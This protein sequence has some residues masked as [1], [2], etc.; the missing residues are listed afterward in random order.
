MHDASVTTLSDPTSVSAPHRPTGAGDVAVA[1]LL[2]AAELVLAW[3]TYDLASA[4]SNHLNATRAVQWTFLML[5]YLPLALVVAVR[6]LSPVRA[7][8]AGLAALGGGVVVIA[9]YEFLLWVFEHRVVNPSYHQ[10]RALG[11]ATVMA[12]SVLAALAW[13]LS[14]RHGRRWPVGL[15]VAAGGAWLTL[16]TDWPSK[17]GWSTFVSPLDVTGIRRVELVHA[18]DLMVPIVAACVVC[19]L[20]DRAEIGSSA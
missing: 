18:L 1:L 8:A 5:P 14:R 11:Y 20:I 6:A 12:A 7:L 2:I 19:W 4:L 9:H 17:L 13:G 15:L 3:F 10:M 16:W